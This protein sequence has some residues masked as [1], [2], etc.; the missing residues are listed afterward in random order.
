MR[1]HR[2]FHILVLSIIL[3]LV[4]A[5]P[6]TPAYAAGENIHL[7]PKEGEIGD[8]IDIEGDGFEAKTTFRIYFSSDAADEGE[9]IDTEVTSYYSTGIK[10]T[11]VAG[12]FVITFTVPSQ[13]FD[14]EDKEDVHGGNYYFYVTYHNTTTILDVAKF[15]VIGGGIEINPE[16]G[17]V[18]TEVEISGKRFG[19]GQEISVK[20]D[21]DS[22]DIASGD[23]KTDDEGEF[24]CIII[25]PESTF[26]DHTITVTDESGNEPE[27][28]FSVKPKI[29]IDPTSGTVGEV[30]TVSGTGFEDRAYMII[31]FDDYRISTT[32][33][34][35]YTRGNGSFTGSFV[36]PSRAVRGTS[37][38][39][40]S[41]EDYNWAEAELTILTGISL[42][43]ATSQTSPGHVGMELTIHG[44]GFIAQTPITITY[45]KST[46]ATVTTDTKGTFSA[47]F[48]MP[49]SIAGS[50]TITVTDGTDTLT[51][52]VTMESE[53]PPIPVPLLPQVATMTEGK[54]YFDWGDVDDP[55]GITYTLQIGADVDFTTIALE[56]TGL[57]QSE[58]AFKVEE[59]LKSTGKD[60][61]YY[62]RVR[63]ID[64]AFNEGKWTMPI[65]FY[66]GRFYQEA[67]PSWLPYLWIGL[68]A[69]LL[70]MLGF[71]VFKRIKG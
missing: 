5:F 71:W 46:V 10:W 6:T 28:E 44:T 21:G 45:D 42:D 22:I 33:L 37:K 61:P 36:V 12:E 67:T 19:I 26:G 8:K 66:V 16:A 15:T 58:Y 20:Y 35:L 25:I 31:T 60:A 56:Q 68:G 62:W 43:P 57:T 9:D 7:S 29:T 38:I 2:I 54:T 40:A 64:G 30:I 3:S 17:Q 55:S 34:S 39:R 24:T 50:H 69:L 18:G 65:L 59:K 48:T 27:A 52:T 4:V 1:Y 11:D 13:L 63:A 51:A 47:T 23:E 32:P 41:D 53:A 49:P 14:G 70:G